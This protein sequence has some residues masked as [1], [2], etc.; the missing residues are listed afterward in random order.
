MDPILRRVLFL[1]SMLGFC[2]CGARLAPAPRV[3][4][5]VSSAR[6]FMEDYGRDLRTGD[7]DALVAR[8]DPRGVYF[9]GGKGM[10]L[11]SFD[12]VRAQYH[13][14]WQAP[15]SFEW[16]DLAFEPVG[17]DAVIITGHFDW[18]SPNGAMSVDYA[19]LLCRQ[20]GAWRIRVEDESQTPRRPEPRFCAAGLLPS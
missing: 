11:V 4:D 18:G 5:P 17:A 12:S 8:Y 2:A 9:V 16:H 6:A 15:T 10:A 14:G 7:R 19:A 20:A 1:G 3:S 13:G